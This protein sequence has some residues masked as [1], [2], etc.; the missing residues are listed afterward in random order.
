[1][2]IRNECTRPVPD[3]FYIPIES[4]GFKEMA[5]SFFPSKEYTSCLGT[6]VMW[7]ISLKSFR[8]GTMLHM[9][10]T[11]KWDMICVT[12]RV[13]DEAC[14]RAAP[15]HK[16]RPQITNPTH[17]YLLSIKEEDEKLKRL[18]ELHGERWDFVASHFPGIKHF[19]GLFIWG[20]LSYGKVI[21]LLWTRKKISIT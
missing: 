13:S 9:W 8:C 6:K 19:L 5:K 4:K 16:N 11:R 2:Y 17:P 20:K 7:K 3:F 21:V 14:Y 12:T 10:C 15:M 1:M 18:V